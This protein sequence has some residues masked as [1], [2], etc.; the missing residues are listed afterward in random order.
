MDQKEKRVMLMQPKQ[1]A[2]IIE[3]FQVKKGVSNPASV[4]LM[5]NEDDSHLLH[6][7]TDYMSKCAMLMFLSQRTYPE[8]C[9]AT[10]KLST[11]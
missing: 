8:I 11:K 1:V 9:P 10:M 7:Q 5:G 4:K 6:N 2:R 3:T